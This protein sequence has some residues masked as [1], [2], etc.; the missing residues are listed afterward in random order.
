MDSETCRKGNCSASAARLYEI[1]QVFDVPIASMFEDIP[2]NAAGTEKERPRGPAFKEKAA[3]LTRRLRG[4]GPSQEVTKP[5]T[6]FEGRRSSNI[7]NL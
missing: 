5:A 7:T 6:G 2:R 1:C 3:E 4:D